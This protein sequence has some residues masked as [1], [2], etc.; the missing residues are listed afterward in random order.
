LAELAKNKINV[1]DKEDAQKLLERAEKIYASIEQFLTH[2][3][4]PRARE[5]I[6][7]ELDDRR[8]TLDAVK[9][10]L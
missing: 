4:S 7:R 9:R 10:L 3:A 2:I 6:K 1:G 8:V 5:E